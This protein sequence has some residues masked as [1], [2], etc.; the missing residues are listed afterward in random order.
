MF[1]WVTWSIWSL[2]LIILVIWVIFPLKEF[3][4]ILKAQHAAHKERTAT[5]ADTPS[6]SEARDDA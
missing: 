4:A 1:D 3:A 2:G 5:D 6:E